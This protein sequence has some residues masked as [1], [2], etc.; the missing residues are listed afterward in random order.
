MRS[1]P[2]NLQL[3]QKKGT[4]IMLKIFAFSIMAFI[5]NRANCNDFLE[6]IAL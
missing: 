5:V 2:L 3:H 6:I 1:V 4:R